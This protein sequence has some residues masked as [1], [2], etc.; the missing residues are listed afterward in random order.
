LDVPKDLPDSTVRTADAAPANRNDLAIAARGDVPDGASRLSSVT[1]PPVS[2]D[3]S[4]SSEKS[5]DGRRLFL[6]AK[7]GRAST[8]GR[9]KFAK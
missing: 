6:P 2:A 4:S 7:N 5:D 9:V 3:S 1:S 8:R